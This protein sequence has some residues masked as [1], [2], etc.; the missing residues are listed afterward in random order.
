[1]AEDFGEF[2]STPHEYLQNI[3]ILYNHSR[4]FNALPRMRRSESLSKGSCAAK[5]TLPVAF[6]A[7][8]QTMRHAVTPSGFCRARQYEK[9]L[10][11]AYP[12]WCAV[13]LSGS[14]VM[15]ERMHRTGGDIWHSRKSL[16][17]VV[18]DLAEVDAWIEARKEAS[19]SAKTGTPM[20]PDVRL[21]QYRPM[22]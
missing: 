3:Y 17:C 5:D 18:W 20:G 13:V 1:M 14:L 12:E 8:G 15:A 16:R 2:H 9:A 7:F 11:K 6:L 4:R 19:R 22:Q 21:R 10:L